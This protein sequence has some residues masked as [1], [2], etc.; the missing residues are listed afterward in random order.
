MFDKDFS[1]FINRR[2]GFIRLKMLKWQ[3]LMPFEHFELDISSP[4]PNEKHFS[5]SRLGF[6]NFGVK[7]CMYD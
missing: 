2:Y 3:Q 7:E 5:F 1:S 6:E 4:V